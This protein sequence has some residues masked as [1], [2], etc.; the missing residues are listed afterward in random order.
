MEKVSYVVVLP[1]FGDGTF[2][3]RK[4][5][6]KRRICLQHQDEER[7]SI[8]WKGN[9]A[10][11]SHCPCRI[12]QCTQ[13]CPRQWQSHR[14]TPPQ[15]NRGHIPTS[16]WDE[17]IEPDDGEPASNRGILIGPA[18]VTDRPT[19]Q[20]DV[21]FCYLPLQAIRLAHKAGLT[22]CQEFILF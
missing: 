10:S 1:L 19:L 12:L 16:W 11:S 18:L 3:P 4:K 15:G 9:P 2:W 8:T 14:L 21:A 13:T 7:F 22:W 17:Q 5:K 20:E 6:I